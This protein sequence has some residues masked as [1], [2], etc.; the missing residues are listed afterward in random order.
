M[1][2]KII[3]LL[4]ACLLLVS[5]G[6]GPAQK[7]QK[8]GDSL[9]PLALS[10]NFYKRYKGKLGEDLFITMCLQRDSSVAGGDTLLSGNYYYDKIGKPLSLKGSL[11]KEVEISL[12]ETDELHKK[13]G[14]FTG[15]FTGPETIEGTW[16]N[17]LT[18]KTY[19]FTLTETKDGFVGVTTKA[20]HHENCDS[21]TKHLRMHDSIN[22]FT[23]T[24][25]SYIDMNVAEI[26]F[27]N[28]H[29]EE[30]IN[31]AIVTIMCSFVDTN[32]TS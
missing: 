21:R 25:C 2:Q 26:Q 14:L 30:V 17:P 22:N 10:K 1:N 4:S 29:I 9:V 23:D 27:S 16:K 6:S 12:T 31:K 19:P 7:N 20:Y 11:K 18:G 28:K 15:K 3:L 32:A 13:T 8:T 5:C 24:M